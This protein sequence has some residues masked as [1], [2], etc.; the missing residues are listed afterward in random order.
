MNYK[1]NCLSIHKKQSPMIAGSK[2]SE[3][4]CREG[5]IHCKR[6]KNKKFAV[7]LCLVETLEKLHPLSL[8]HMAAYT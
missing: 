6:P 5:W 2:G 1:E 7:R 4:L 3:I 8:T